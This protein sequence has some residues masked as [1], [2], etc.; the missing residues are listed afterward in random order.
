MFKSFLESNLISKQ[1]YV[2]ITRLVN[3]GN[4]KSNEVQ[5]TISSS[6]YHMAGSVLR[7]FYVLTHLTCKT[8]N[9]M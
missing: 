9:V 7:V 2:E 3:V 4:R 6:S 5:N 1:N 8:L